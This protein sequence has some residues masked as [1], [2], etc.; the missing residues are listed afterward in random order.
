[1]DTQAGA[2]AASVCP[3][4]PAAGEGALQPPTDS[5][6]AWEVLLQENVQLRE[7]LQQWK[8]KVGQLG[9]PLRVFIAWP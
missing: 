3:R 5:A 4:L 9:G 8:A 2:Q 1:M 6:P 7:D